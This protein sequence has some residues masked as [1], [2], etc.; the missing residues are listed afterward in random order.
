M[1]LPQA[2]QARWR[3]QGVA[4][5][6]DTDHVC[7]PSKLDLF[8]MVKLE[9]E[10][11]DMIWSRRVIGGY[12]RRGAD[13]LWSKV[14]DDEASTKAASRVRWL[15]YSWSILMRFQ[16]MVGYLKKKQSRLSMYLSRKIRRSK[17]LITTRRLWER[18]SNKVCPKMRYK[19]WWWWARRVM[20]EPCCIT[21]G[22]D[23]SD[24]LD[25]LH[26]W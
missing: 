17:H 23:P 2:I 20:N 16:N 4:M 19:M 11:W 26:C 3:V 15:G 25:P 14:R 9:G 8:H 1:K 18:G 12:S 7:N 5:E 22:H 13:Q 10:C 24:S 21:W 6:Y